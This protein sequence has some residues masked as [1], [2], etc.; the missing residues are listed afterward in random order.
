MNMLFG[1]ATSALMIP[2]RS[3]QKLMGGPERNI[4]EYLVSWIDELLVFVVFL[5]F[6]RWF[7][8]SLFTV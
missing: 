4:I 2:Q 7:L 1:I 6:L 3:E 5:N 8:V